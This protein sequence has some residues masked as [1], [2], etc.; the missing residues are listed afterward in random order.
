MNNL[1]VELINK[2]IM[3]S[4]PQYPYFEE[5]N[6]YLCY[7]EFFWGRK[8][9]YR[10]GEIKSFARG[11]RWLKYSKP[12]MDELE[13]IIHSYGH[14]GHPQYI[15]VTD[16]EDDEFY[17]EIDYDPY[18]DPN[19]MNFEDFALEFKYLIGRV[20]RPIYGIEWKGLRRD[21]L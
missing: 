19:Q 17:K 8:L 11:L 3:M 20:P 13:H 6:Y 5:L 12:I 15:E 21:L 16:S 18:L 7:C 4:R 10:L 1:P 14:E 2:I 9:I